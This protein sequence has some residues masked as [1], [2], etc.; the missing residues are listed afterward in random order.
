MDHNDQKSRQPLDDW[1][2]SLVR[3]WMSGFKTKLLAGLAVIAPL[4]ITGWTAARAGKDA[5]DSKR[6]GNIGLAALAELTLMGTAAEFV[7]LLDLA[8]LV[9]REVG[10]CRAQRL[11]FVRHRRRPAGVR[12]AG[13]G[14]RLRHGPG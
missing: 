8:N 9:G 6:V 11:E 14:W 7:G 2:D 3:R 1:L 10:Q 12:R 13:C 5:G 4:W